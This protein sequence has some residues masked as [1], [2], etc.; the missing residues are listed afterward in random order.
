MARH[1]EPTC[2]IVIF[3]RTGPVGRFCGAKVA[4]TLT[5][6]DQQR[7]T[8][9]PYLCRTFQSAYGSALLNS[10]LLAGLLAGK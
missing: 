9:D 1:V 6:K 4:R 8:A 5:D 10:I 3:H 2:T 7:Q